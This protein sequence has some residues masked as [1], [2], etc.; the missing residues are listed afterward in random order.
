MPK[1]Y[2]QGY[3]NQPISLG[4]VGSIRKMAGATSGLWPLSCHHDVCWRYEGS[5]VTWRQ[6]GVYLHGEGEIIATQPLGSLQRT[7]RLTSNV[8]TTVLKAGPLRH[9]PLICL[10]A[11]GPS[12]AEVSQKVEKVHLGRVVIAAGGRPQDHSLQSSD[13]SMPL[14]PTGLAGAGRAAEG[15]LPLFLSL[16]LLLQLSASHVFPRIEDLQI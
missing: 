13:A 14:P 15:W 12:R 2:T 3:R 7:D 10:E 6:V 16:L 11:V 9:V 1:G 5:Q 4:R 8:T